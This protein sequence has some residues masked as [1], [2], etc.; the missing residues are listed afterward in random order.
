MVGKSIQSI[1]LASNNVKN[2][3]SLKLSKCS[4]QLIN[5][6]REIQFLKAKIKA[7][8]SF[9]SRQRQEFIMRIEGMLYK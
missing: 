9:Y 4:R 1:K 5:A 6:N 2:T 3:T 7:L 8:N